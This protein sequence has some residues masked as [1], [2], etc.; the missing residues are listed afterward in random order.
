MCA[1]VLR[2]VQNVRRSRPWRLLK[3]RPYLG[4][5]KLWAS[6]KFL[7]V[8]VIYFCPAV[9]ARGSAKQSTSEVTRLVYCFTYNLQAPHPPIASCR[10]HD[11]ECVGT[12]CLCCLGWKDCHDNAELI[13]GI[14]TSTP[15]SSSSSSSSRPSAFSALWQS[16]PDDNLE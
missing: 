8:C 16:S 13:V 5:C 1:Y 3:I 6:R 10:V 12:L 7:Q 4:L 2:G 15:S 14:N 11:S 9:K